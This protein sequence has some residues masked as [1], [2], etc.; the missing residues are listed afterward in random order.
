M[1][2]L[3]IS[4]INLPSALRRSAGFLQLMGIIPGR[5]E[6]K[7]IDPYIEVLIDDLRSVNG[8]KLYDSHQKNWFTLQAELLLHVLDYPGQNKL[9]NCHGEFPK[10]IMDVATDGKI[11]ICNLTVIHAL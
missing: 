6:P 5:N 10:I 9:F 8:T 11:K 2:P 7:H 3:V 1:W 4:I